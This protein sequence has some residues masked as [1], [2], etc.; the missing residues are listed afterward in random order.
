[1]S[2]T[3]PTPVFTITTEET[4]FRMA[5]SII[6]FLDKPIAYVGGSAYGDTT[7]E[8][9]EE[10]LARAFAPILDRIRADHDTAMVSR[11][12]IDYDGEY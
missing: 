11:F 6:W 4:D 5:E 1:M 12:E 3:I 2:I 10:V 7:R 8:A 9:A